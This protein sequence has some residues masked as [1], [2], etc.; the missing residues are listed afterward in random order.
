MG[1]VTIQARLRGY[2]YGPLNALSGIVEDS[3]K[4]LGIVDSDG[5]EDY[6]DNTSEQIAV[7]QRQK[8]VLTIAQGHQ[9]F[10]FG[11]GE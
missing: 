7:G 1:E 3:G 8:G 6:A 11:L 5:N 10:S 9:A 2:T 4:N